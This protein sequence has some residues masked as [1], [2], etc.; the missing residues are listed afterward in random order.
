MDEAEEILWEAVASYKLTKEDGSSLVHGDKFLPCLEL[1]I[2]VLEQKGGSTRLAQADWLWNQIEE[3]KA[4][5][6]AM[7][8][9]ALEGTS[10]G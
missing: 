8:V 2:D 7:Y 4:D 3:R 9:G 10:A 1:L 6:E 5:L